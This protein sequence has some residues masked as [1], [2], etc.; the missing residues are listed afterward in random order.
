ML[1]CGP[2]AAYGAVRT[3]SCAESRPPTHPPPGP[4]LPKS[5]PPCRA[6]RCCWYWLRAPSRHLAPPPFPLYPPTPTHPTPYPLPSPSLIL[7]PPRRRR[8]SSRSCR[9]RA[10]RPSSCRRAPVPPHPLTRRGRQQAHVTHSH[11][12]A[13]TH[14]AQQGR[15]RAGPP[16]AVAARRP[17]PPR[18]LALPRPRARARKRAHAH[19]PLTWPFTCTCLTISRRYGGRVTDRRRGAARTDCPARSRRLSAPGLACG[20]GWGRGGGVVSA[21]A[22]A[23]RREAPLFPLPPVRP[24]LSLV[25]ERGG[26]LMRGGE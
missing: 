3:R 13:H 23:P 9:G 17:C 16:P 15:H 4:A 18:S 11:A 7:C 5:A 12:R 24:P 22:D 10:A 6:S 1:L 2:T 21:V 8:R 26:A 25:R 14:D 20:V 19:N